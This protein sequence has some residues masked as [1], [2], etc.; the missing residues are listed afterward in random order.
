M[1]VPA[2]LQIPSKL[3]GIAGAMA[4]PLPTVWHSGDVASAVALCQAQGSL[5]LVLVEPTPSGTASALLPPCA[6]YMHGATRALHRLTFSGAP[7]A[8]ALASAR[9]VAL[10]LVDGSDALAAFAAFVALPA[11]RPVVFLLAPT[12]AVLVRREGFVGPR[13]L[14]A[15][16]QLADETLRDP[17]AAARRAEAAAALLAAAA[18]AAP[19]QA[20]DHESNTSE[21]A[22]EHAVRG[23]LQNPSAEQTTRSEPEAK[24]SSEPEPAPSRRTE[25]KPAAVQ[26]EAADP[27][28]VARAAGRG[29]SRPMQLRPAG[30]SMRL[31]VRLPDGRVERRTFPASTAFGT[32]RAWAAEA[33]ELPSSAFLLGTTFPR[34]VYDAADDRAL[35]SALDGL[36]DGAALFVTPV[37]SEPAATP[38]APQ[39]YVSAAAGY[40]RSWIPGLGDNSRV[41]GDRREGGDPGRS[42]ADNAAVGGGA[43][44]VGDGRP[45]DSMAELRRREGGATGNLR[46]DNGNSTQFGAGG[47]DDTS[48]RGS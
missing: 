18:A 21:S 6:L 26:K 28:V 31:G 23:N 46:Y 44:G 29:G 42:T 7:L 30:D 36:T 13:D 25:A 16:V 37:A 1:N 15:C 11:A 10:R 3:D 27:T 4:K 5:L 39:G 17:G 35:L 22:G 48:R 33:A 38:S 14:A 8:T 40:L 20:K 19:D 47:D 12:G 24:A 34:R 45:S 2:V 32:V 43:A 9:A 41:T